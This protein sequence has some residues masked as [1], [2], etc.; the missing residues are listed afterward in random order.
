MLKME[1][2]RRAVLGAAMAIGALF[3]QAPVAQA[4]NFNNGDLIIVLTK[5]NVDAIYDFGAIASGSQAFALPTQFGGS[6]SGA[7]VNVLAVQFPDLQSP[8][9]GFGPLPLENLVF[10]TLNA[11]TSTAL[12]D[13]PSIINAAN[14]LGYANPVGWLPNTSQYQLTLG[15]TANSVFVSGGAQGIP[16]AYSASSGPG[17]VGQNQIFSAF[18]VKTDG[19]IDGTGGLLVPLWYAQRGYTEFD[20]S[21]PASIVS[22]IGTLS[23][24]G[25]GSSTTASLSLTSV[26]EPGTLLLM[27]AGILGL[28]VVG[29]R[30]D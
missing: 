21:A 4:L 16:G 12:I 13:D 19:N 9:F 6:A 1:L 8:D 23:F 17:N 27:T 14:N 15:S 7:N 28:G 30:R 25:A 5:N 29:R 24:S 18:P 26:P 10:S 11:Q 20:P 3:V 2:G 22:Q